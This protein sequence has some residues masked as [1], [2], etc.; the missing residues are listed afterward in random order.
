MAALTTAVYSGTERLTDG[1]FGGFVVAF[2]TEGTGQHYYLLLEQ[3]GRFFKL[4]W[5]PA[6]GA[7]KAGVSDVPGAVRYVQVKSNAGCMK[8]GDARLSC[9]DIKRLAEQIQ[10][11]IQNILVTQVKPGACTG[12]ARTTR[13]ATTASASATPCAKRSA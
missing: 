2:F 9:E 13:T 6:A 5:G 4:D 3:G 7:K 11:Q 8:L 12:G 1:A 10:I